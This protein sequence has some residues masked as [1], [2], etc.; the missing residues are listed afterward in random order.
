MVATTEH[1]HIQRSIWKE[2]ARS[3]KRPEIGVNIREEMRKSVILKVQGAESLKGAQYPVIGERKKIHG[4]QGYCEHFKIRESQRG[5]ERVK[6]WIE[7]D[8]RENGKSHPEQRTL[9]RCSTGTWR[10]R[11]KCPSVL[12]LL[13]NE[14][15]QS[16]LPVAVK[17]KRKYIC[18]TLI[19]V[20]GT[21]QN[22]LERHLITIV[23]Q[24][25]PSNRPEDSKGNCEGDQVLIQAS[26]QQVESVL[27][28][29]E[30]G[31]QSLKKPWYLP[32]RRIFVSIAAVSIRWELGY[33]FIWTHLCKIP[34]SQVLFLSPLHYFLLYKKSLKSDLVMEHVLW[35]NLCTL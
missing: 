19:I 5:G 31:Q 24:S 15:K 13:Q 33:G 29:K 27:K 1:V 14:E 10:L 26:P 28:I 18:E 9:L 25:F 8:W 7:A 21:N 17:T 11:S 34:P 16:F 32:S 2:W 30:T 20:P 23:V 6:K 4:N 22:P 12:P 35:N 3:N